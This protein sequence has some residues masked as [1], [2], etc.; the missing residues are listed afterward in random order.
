MNIKDLTTEAALDIRGGANAI[1]QSSVNYGATGVVSVGGGAFN[2]SP[3]TISSQVVQANLTEQAAQ[4]TDVY[5]R[6]TRIGIAGSQLFA[7]LPFR[8]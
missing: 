3:V 4:I 2:G 1:S 7:G 8:F 5:Q 6:D